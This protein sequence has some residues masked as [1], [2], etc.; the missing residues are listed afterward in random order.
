MYADTGIPEMVKRL[1]ER[2]AN[3]HR[4]VVQV[5]GGAQ[6]F[7]DHG[8]FNIGKRNHVSMRKAI[9]KAGMFIHA[10][11]VG[12]NLSRTVLLE[13]GSGR[14]LV[15]QGGLPAQELVPSRPKGGK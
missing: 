9:W 10:E 3:K 1:V 13:I 14:F 7:D 8:L 15:R 5:A 2:G 4:L 6:V 11:A 12:G